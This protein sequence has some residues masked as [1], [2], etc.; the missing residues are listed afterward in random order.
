MLLCAE[1]QESVPHV[2]SQQESLM[3]RMDAATIQP[4]NKAHFDPP[5]TRQKYLSYFRPLRI[6]HAS[7]Q[8]Q[9]GNR[10]ADLKVAQQLSRIYT[11]PF[12]FDDVMIPEDDVRFYHLVYCIC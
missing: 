9:G 8:Q 12:K 11:R 10:Y 5:Y 2:P 3:D 4:F 6:G 1:T 7:L